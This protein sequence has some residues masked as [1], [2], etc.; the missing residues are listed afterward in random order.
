MEKLTMEDIQGYVIRGYK[1]M[2]FSRYLLL[3]VTDREKACGFLGEIS[4]LLTNV[5]HHAKTSCLNIA[6]TAQGLRALGL[7]ESN[8]ERFSREFREGMITPHRQRLLGDMDSSGPENWLWGAPGN[9]EVHFLLMIF[10]AHRDIALEHY[11][12][13]Q[14]KFS[15]WG[16]REIR[17]MD[18]QTLP[19]NKEH[20]GFRDGIS[21]P[22]IKGSGRTGPAN[23]YINAGEFIMGYR[24]EYG[25]FPDSPLLTEPQ[26][27]AS[28]LPSDPSGSGKKDLGCNGTYMVLRQLRQDVDGYWTFLNEKTKNENGTINAEASLKLSAKM[29]GRWPSGASVLKFPDTDPGHMS[30]DN[31]FNYAQMDPDGTRCPFGSHLRRNNPRDSFEDN[32]PAESLRLTKR[33]RIM[34]RARLYG[35]PFEGSPHHHS[36]EGEVGLLFTCFNTDISRQFEFLQYTWSNYPKIKQLYCDPDPITGIRE[37]PEPGTHQ[38]FTIQ[39]RPV[40]TFITGLKRFVT[41]KGGAYFFFPSIRAVR[42][43]STL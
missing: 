8:L 31:D 24:N 11:E 3:Q 38:H 37:N 13:F 2:R 42:Y 36:P 39:D 22:V 17:Q 34:R 16:V 7:K 1:H 6:V 14:A 19:L 21:Q 30:D 35:V 5:D 29:M 43:L 32:G 28:L 18:G 9:E 27:D 25:V 26:G 12:K 40:N 10:G 20:F 23:D 41:V 33:H 4:S 15:G